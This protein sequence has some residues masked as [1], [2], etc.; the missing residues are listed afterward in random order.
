MLH[1]VVEHANRLKSNWKW[2]EVYGL[3]VGYNKGTHVLIEDA[4]PITHGSSIHVRFKMEDYVF[5]ATVNDLLV[6]KTNKHFFVGWYHSHPGL[7]LF[8]SGT[9]VVNHLGFQ[10]LNPL[11]CAIVFDHSLIELN[12]EGFQVFRLTNNL[13]GYSTVKHKII[14]LKQKKITK[15]NPIEEIYYRYVHYYRMKSIINTEKQVRKNLK[16]WLLI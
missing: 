1:H 7:G 4:I 11:A 9:D 6:E 5:A 15:L 14:D 2:K 8:L 12:D 16:R 3:L 10:N 13:M